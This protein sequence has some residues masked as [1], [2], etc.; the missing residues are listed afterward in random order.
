MDYE[1]ILL[2]A[3]G[4][5]FDYDKAEANALEKTFNYFNLEYK[6]EQDLKEL[7]RLL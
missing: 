5:L 3:D 2:D 4:T 7:F 1:V 6:E